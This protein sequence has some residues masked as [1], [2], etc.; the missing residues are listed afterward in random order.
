MLPYLVHAHRYA[1][2]KLPH[3]IGGADTID[4]S[5]DAVE[6]H[7]ADPTVADILLADN[8]QKLSLLLKG[9]PWVFDEVRTGLLGSHVFHDVREQMEQRGL[10]SVLELYGIFSAHPPV[11]APGEQAEA[12]VDIP[13]SVPQPIAA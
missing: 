12:P 2:T 9:E 13:Q 8:R 6:M 1:D 11:N 4:A 10:R 7:L 3:A 5:I